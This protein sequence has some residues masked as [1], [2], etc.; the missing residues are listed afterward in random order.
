[1][2]FRKGIEISGIVQGV[3]FRPFIYRLATENNLTGFITNTEAG[4]S[5][6]VEGSAEAIEAFLARLPKEAPPLARITKIVVADRP[7]EPR[8]RFPHPAEPR[9]G[10]AHGLDL[11]RRGHLRRLPGGVAQSRRPPIPLPFHQLHQLRPALHHRAGYPLR[12]RQDLDGG[13]SHVPGM[14]ARIR[15]PAQSP[16][17]CPTECLLELRPAR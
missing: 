1:M 16:L 5:I 6:E 2:S 3:G 7:S 17:P 15:R 4:V 13:L 10:R 12:P 8:R 9:R 14:P 11:A